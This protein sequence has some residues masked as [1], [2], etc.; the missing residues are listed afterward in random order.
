MT[1]FRQVTLVDALAI[2]ADIENVAASCDCHIG[3]TGGILYKQGPR[4]DID[5][6]VYKHNTEETAGKPVR[7]IDFEAG[8]EKLGIVFGKRGPRVTKAVWY[9]YSIDF[10]YAEEIGQYTEDPNVHAL[11]LEPLDD[12]F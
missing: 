7:R 4:K 11:V 12:P 2:A 1:D 5:F 3:L 9:N 10:I 8:L 6:V